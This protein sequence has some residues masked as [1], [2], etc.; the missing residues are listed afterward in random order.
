MVIFRAVILAEIRSVFMPVLA[1][2][3]CGY[4]LRW[5]S[6]DACSMDKIPFYFAEGLLYRYGVDPG[7]WSFLAYMSCSGICSSPRTDSLRISCRDSS[8]LAAVCAGLFVNSP[9]ACG[10]GRPYGQKSIGL[11]KAHR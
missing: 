3:S 4:I 6:Q 7:L 1:I 10:R 9:P 5:I 8:F 11:L 2:C